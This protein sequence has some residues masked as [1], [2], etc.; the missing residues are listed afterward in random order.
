MGDSRI[1]HIV[2]LMMENRSFDH[3][4]G[5]LSRE[6]GEIRG[7]RGGDFSN[8]TTAGVEVSVSEGAQFQ[9]QLSDPGHDF[10]ARGLDSQCQGID[11]VPDASGAR[12]DQQVT[13]RLRRGPLG[14]GRASRYGEQEG[15]KSCG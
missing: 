14:R 4:L 7:V 2:V 10:G 6:N 3:L 13:R 1:Q 5:F 8:R 9:G 12:L 15:T 11:A